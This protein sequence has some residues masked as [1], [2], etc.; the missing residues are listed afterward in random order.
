MTRKKDRWIKPREGK[1]VQVKLRY[2]VGGEVGFV[3]QK[4]LFNCK[5]NYTHFYPKG[6]LY[7]TN[8]KS[9]GKFA[10]SITKSDIVKS[11]I[12]KSIRK[13]VCIR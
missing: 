9:Y 5:T 1:L 13:K 10:R 4:D 6:K 2:D 3:P 12:P 8:K 11:K 7:A